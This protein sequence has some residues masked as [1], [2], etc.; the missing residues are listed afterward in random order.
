MASSILLVSSWGLIFVSSDVGVDG[1]PVIF[2]L[3]SIDFAIGRALGVAGGA[4][5]A[6][7]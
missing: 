7:A 2:I 5:A 3:I 1:V 6:S 4:L